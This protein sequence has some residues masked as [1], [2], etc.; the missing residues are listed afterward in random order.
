MGIDAGE[1]RVTARTPDTDLERPP[2]ADGG[3]GTIR[4]ERDGAIATVVIANRSRR[5]A[6]SQ[7]MWRA[8]ADRFETLSVDDTVRC[9]VLRGAGEEAFSAGADI[10]EFEAIRGSAE[11]ARAYDRLTGPALAAVTGCR[12]PVV[13]AIHGACVGG[14][15]EL[16]ACADMRLCGE[17]SI[18]AVP[19]ARLGLVLRH[20]ELHRLVAL[21]GPANTREILFEVAPLDAAHALRIGLVNRVVADHELSAAVAATAA[22]IARLAP[23]THRWHKQ[24]LIRLE[25]AG[26]GAVPGAER[27]SAYALYD[28]E[29]FR[30]GYRAFL[31]KRRSDFKGR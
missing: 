18:F 3:A 2:V 19:S 14:G 20:E 10:S 29:D 26:G 15:L 17:S 9:V 5:N 13:A 31:E 11:A 7:A 23:L 28:S 8:L 6:L 25:E 22:R 16:A 4:C 12:H 27:D 30:E 21:V 1:T 24:A